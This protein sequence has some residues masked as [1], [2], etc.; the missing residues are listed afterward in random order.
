MTQVAW[1]FCNSLVSLLIVPSFPLWDTAYLAI[2]P[3][4][5]RKGEQEN[6]RRKMITEAEEKLADEIARRNA[7]NTRQE[8]DR[9]RICDG[10]EELRALKDFLPT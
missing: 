8:Q 5:P 7:F 2:H 4:L 10:S 6:E 3:T 1:C 9:R